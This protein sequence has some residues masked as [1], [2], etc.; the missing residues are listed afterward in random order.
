MPLNKITQSNTVD[1][2]HDKVVKRILANIVT[3]REILEI[4]LPS[5]VRAI[6]DLNFLERQPDTFTLP[7]L[8]CITATN[9]H[10]QFG[11][12]LGRALRLVFFLTLPAAV[13]LWF[14]AHPIISL[15]L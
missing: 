15:N 7:V 3:V 10:T 4:Y 14:L 9:N 2:P 11:S 1:K 13:G 12:T 6:L 8:S 5:D